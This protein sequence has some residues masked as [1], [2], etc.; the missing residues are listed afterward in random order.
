MRTWSGPSHTAALVGQLVDH[1]KVLAFVPA[2]A[3]VGLQVQGSTA[4]TRELGLIFESNW[5]GVDPRLS[6]VSRN[7]S[8]F[9]RTD[10]QPPCA[11]RKAMSVSEAFRDVVD[12]FVESMGN[13]ATASGPT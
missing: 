1:P 7:R 8:R 4:E 12:K 3:V 9:L 13:C 6:P 11:S 2:E 10:H 5:V